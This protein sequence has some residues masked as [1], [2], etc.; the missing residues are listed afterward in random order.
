[1]TLARLGRQELRTVNII[2]KTN[3]VTLFPLRSI[4]PSFHVSAFPTKLTFLS[5][6]PWRLLCDALAAVSDALPQ[7]RNALAEKFLRA[8]H[9]DHFN[10]L[11]TTMATGKNRMSA[12]GHKAVRFRFRYCSFAYI[13]PITS[14]RI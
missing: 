4:K 7:R 11:L 5:V 14:T 8:I 10:F 2:T 1:M 3:P 6:I 12:Y 9:L 13:H